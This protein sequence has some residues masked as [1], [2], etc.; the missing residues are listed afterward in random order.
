MPRYSRSYRSRSSGYR[1]RYSRRAGW[2]YP[3]RRY[4]RRGKYAN[5]SSR[6]VVRIK[7]MSASTLTCGTGAGS[8]PSA[9]VGFDAFSSS[10]STLSALASPLYREYTKLYEEVKCIGVRVDMSV[11]DA[12]GGATLP[13]VQIYT[14]WDRRHGS[15]EAAPAAGNI[16]SA[17]TSACT[18]ALNNSIA[19]TRRSIWASDL[20]EKAQWHDCSLST[21]GSGFSDDAWNA[22]TSNPNFFCPAFFCTFLSPTLAVAGTMRVN[23]QVVYYMAFRNPKY[24][25]SGSAKGSVSS[26]MD[27]V[28]DA[29]DPDEDPLR[30]EDELTRDADII[31]KRR[32][33]LNRRLKV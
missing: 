9:V 25:L 30:I 16:V 27:T 32:S 12:I 20:L 26:E 29:Q 8:T 14:C 1:R 13:S 17:S 19:R 22:A 5:A 23:F 28:P 4:Y 10:S 7:T 18:V 11:V 3:Y 21:D 6:S 15:A 24:G 33:I 2:R 31:S